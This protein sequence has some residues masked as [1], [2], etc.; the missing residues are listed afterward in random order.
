MKKPSV[1]NAKFVVAKPRNLN[2]CFVN[3]PQD[4]T[5]RTVAVSL[6]SILNQVNHHTGEREITS[7]SY[8]QTSRRLEISLKEMS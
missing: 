4:L 6:S 5:V 8:D 3:F 1:T 7:I 2:L